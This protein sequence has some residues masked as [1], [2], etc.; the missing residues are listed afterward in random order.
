MRFP[1]HREPS[2]NMWARMTDTDDSLIYSE[3]KPDGEDWHPVVNHN[4][5]TRNRLE[6]YKSGSETWN[7]E[8]NALLKEIHKSKQK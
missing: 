6:L 8:A 4:R 1:I 3:S 2:V 5:A 7:R